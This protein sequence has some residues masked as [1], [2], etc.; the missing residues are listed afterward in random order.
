[1]PEEFMAK[2][3]RKIIW[4]IKPQ[5]FKIPGKVFTLTS[6]IRLMDICL[7]RKKEENA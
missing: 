5:T 2:S 6:E 3:D 1:M 4:I 7:R